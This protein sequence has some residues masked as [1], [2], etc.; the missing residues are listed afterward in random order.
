MAPKQ[1]SRAK[2]HNSSPSTSN[3]NTENFEQTYGNIEEYDSNDFAHS[4]RNFSNGSGKSSPVRKTNRTRMNRSI[5]P[6]SV[7][8]SNEDGLDTVIERVNTNMNRTW[9]D[10]DAPRR[11]IVLFRSG[12]KRYAIKAVPAWSA[13]VL[14]E[15]SVYKQ[16][17]QSKKPGRFSFDPKHV[18]RFVDEGKTTVRVSP[19]AKEIVFPVRLRSGTVDVT[20]TGRDTKLVVDGLKMRARAVG[21]KDSLVAVHF[22]VTEAPEVFRDALYWYKELRRSTLTKDVRDAF[23][24]RFFYAFAPVLLRAHLTYRFGHFDFHPG[25]MMCKIMYKQRTITRV[26]D[27]P[28]SIEGMRHVT[29][30]PKIYDFDLSYSSAPV[31]KI[32]P[33]LVKY[34]D[35]S[36]TNLWLHGVLLQNDETFWK[37]YGIVYDLT[38]LHIYF[39]RKGNKQLKADARR[40]VVSMYPPLSSS[41]EIV[42]D[43]VEKAA[44]ASTPFYQDNIL[45]TFEEMLERGVRAPELYHHTTNGSSSRGKQASPVRR[46]SV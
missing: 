31:P 1:I 16:L 19:G 3:W 29:V 40:F 44:K 36:D 11:V 14:R 33:S 34:T 43:L 32:D 6:T 12:G 27:L 13:R 46:T 26:R 7:R 37:R 5:S 10:E 35:S 28:H 24:M 8:V 15:I 39:V 20:L 25:N 21:F 38:R 9:F 4:E 18:V 42:M 41:L 45:P 17:S 2:T 23:K 30:V 22:F